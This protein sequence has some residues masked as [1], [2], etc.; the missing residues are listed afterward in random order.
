MDPRLNFG[1]VCDN[2]FVS[3]D[4]KLNIV[5]IFE[6]INT[7]ALAERTPFVMPQFF[8]VLNF[9][10]D[11]SKIYEE[12]SQEVKIIDPKGDTVGVQ[13]LKLTPAYKRMN[14]INAFYLLPFAIKGIYKV[15]ISINGK[16]IISECPLEINVA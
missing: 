5:G 6:R 3:E 4:K 1:V 2:A 10:V 13:E 8:V 14:F 9:T 15:Y 16:E 12:Y 11:E 7:A